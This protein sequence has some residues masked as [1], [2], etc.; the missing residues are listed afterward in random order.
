[1]TDPAQQPPESRGVGAV[2]L[3]IGD[4]LAVIA[5]AELAEP[6]PE[7]VRIRQRMTAAARH[8]RA[9]QVAVEMQELR[10]GKVR[11]RVFG[12]TPVRIAEFA[13]AVEQGHIV[14]L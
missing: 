6:A 12:F 7:H 14:Q 1:M 2:A 9:R 11:L 5:G 8:D 13:A 4:D 3:V 10:A